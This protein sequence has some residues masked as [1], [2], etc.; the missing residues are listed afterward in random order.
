MQNLFFFFISGTE[1]CESKKAVNALNEP[2]R[3]ELLYVHMQD[4]LLAIGCRGTQYQP[5]NKRPSSRRPR[6]T[7]LWSNIARD[8]VRSLLRRREGNTSYIVGG[9][10]DKFPQQLLR[11]IDFD[12]FMSSPFLSTLK[13]QSRCLHSLLADIVLTL[14]TAVT[15]VVPTRLNLD[16]LLRSIVKIWDICVLLITPIKKIYHSTC[17]IDSVS[18]SRNAANGFIVSYIWI[19]M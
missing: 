2:C 12:L 6:V 8:V 16:S 3:M 14:W 11:T 19:N 13:L 1:K 7:D 18:R 10:L 5:F 17:T 4:L 9:R 15:L